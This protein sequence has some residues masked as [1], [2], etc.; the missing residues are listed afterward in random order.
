MIPFEVSESR[1]PVGS[2]AQTMAGL[3]TS[4][5]ATVMLLLAAAHLGRTLGLIREPHH[6]DGV[7]RPLAGL[8]RLLAGDQERKLDVL[9]PR[10]Q[11][12]GCRTGR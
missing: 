1:A 8:F 5:R 11:G 2:S 9:D 6:L 7:L 4:E 3:F 10:G 12:S